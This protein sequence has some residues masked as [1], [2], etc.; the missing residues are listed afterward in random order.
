MT[1]KKIFL[2]LRILSLSMIFS[3]LAFGAGGDFDS[4]TDTLKQGSSAGQTTL[5]LALAWLFT[6]LIPG[7]AIVGAFYGYSF[8][9]KKAE[10]QQEGASKII[11]FVIGLGVLGALAA[12][13]FSALAGLIMRGDSTAIFKVI[14]NFIGNAFT[15]AG[16]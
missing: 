15:A 8:A 11:Y 13:L 1:N 12:V 9:K 10:Q 6:F 2:I 14:W 7:C 3:S 16:V 4:I 5:G